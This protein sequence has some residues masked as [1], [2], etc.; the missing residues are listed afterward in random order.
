[1]VIIESQGLD[2]EVIW[3]ASDYSLMTT[4]TDTV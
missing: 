1:M 3:G 4:W 2:L